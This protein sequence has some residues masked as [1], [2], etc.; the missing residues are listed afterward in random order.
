MADNEEPAE[1][2]RG[3]KAEESKALDA[4]TDL[5]SLIVPSLTLHRNTRCLLSVQWMQ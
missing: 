3:V 1:K 5:V 4:I 2:K